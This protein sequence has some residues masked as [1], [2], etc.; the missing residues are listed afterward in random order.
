MKIRI[1]VCE[2]YLRTVTCT[3]EEN[4]ELRGK[5]DIQ[6]QISE[7]IFSAYNS[8][9]QCNKSNESKKN[10]DKT[11]KWTFGYNIFFNSSEHETAAFIQVLINFIRTGTIHCS[12]RQTNN[13]Y[14]N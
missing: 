8:D 4:C 7:H 6:G 5:E 2:H 1:F 10:G 14:R 12:T 11:L 3:F 13:G 9:L